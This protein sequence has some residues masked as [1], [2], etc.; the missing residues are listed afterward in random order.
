M[1]PAVATAA[2]K[3][4]VDAFCVKD[5]AVWL[6]HVTVSGHVPA[7]AKRLKKT[8]V[9]PS[10]CRWIEK[11]K[12]LCGS[13]SHR[14]L[15]AVRCCCEHCNGDFAAYHPTAICCD[16][17]E[18]TPVF[19]FRVSPGFAVDET[20]CSFITTHANNTTE[21][22]YRMTRSMHSDCW[23]NQAA[24][25]CRAV[26]GKCVRS[27]ILPPGQSTLDVHLVP[28][29]SSKLDH[30]RHEFARLSREL[31]DKESA[32]D[33]DICFA[34]IF[35]RKENRNSIGEMF[36]GTGKKKLLLLMDRDMLTAKEL[37][38]HDGVDPAIKWRWK[39]MVQG[40]FDK[41]EV[42]LHHL[43]QRHAAVKQELELEESAGEPENTNANDN[44]NKAVEK[45]PPMFS[46]L[47]D[48]VGF[49]CRTTSRKSID[50]TV[51]GDFQRRKP[52]QHAKMRSIPATVLK[53]DWH[54]KIAKKVKVHTGRGKCFAPFKSAVS[55]QN[56]DSLTVFWK[57]YPGSESMDTL[58][59]DLQLLKRRMEMLKSMV[60][61]THVDNC[62]HVR[63]KLQTIFP[64]SFVKCD[65]FHW[66]ERWEIILCDSKSEKS[67]A[68][69]T[70][71]RQA[72]FVAEPHEFERTKALLVS[73]G[74]SPTN[75]DML[76]EAK[77]TIP[78]P[79]VLER[80][81]MCTLHTLM[82]KDHE[83]DRARTTVGDGNGIESRFFK[84]GA[85]TSNTIVRQ[86]AHVRKGCPSDP[87]AS[88]AKIHRCNPKTKKTH[89][90]RSTGSNEVDNRCAL[91]S[92]ETPTT[93]ITKADV[94]FNNHCKGSN[95]RKRV[96]R[97]GEEPQLHRSE[98]IQMLHGMAEQCGHE[99]APH[100]HQSHPKE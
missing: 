90:A 70:L 87:D 2:K 42:E 34:D 81:V 4:S 76:K 44:N 45:K 96:N 68:F 75:R 63:G 67:T 9:D 69:R 54:H 62:C 48:P 27:N 74:K 52:I 40:C 61:G 32:F 72:T 7:C 46:T 94:K 89:T 50:R 36:L 53:I 1:S 49:N 41:V 22:I 19:N 55:I 92:M 57:F 51:L 65:L 78:A 99:D 77:A 100:G 25:C 97:L 71:M 66:E 93:S 10:R 80:R 20:L 60:K 64:G 11:P 88:I 91:N 13:H 73:K 30:T 39:E 29:K 6:P 18:M 38:Q 82:E 59:R 23:T 21:S 37:I 24:L 28:H 85:E 17:S 15:D 58:E 33:G 31:R 26:M 14:C 12:T 3:M 43:R 35:R 16:A 98:Q 83:V 47:D 8:G 84:R 95:D 86:M 5:L 56:E 79:D